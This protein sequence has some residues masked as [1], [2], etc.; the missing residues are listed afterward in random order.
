MPLPR[1]PLDQ[2]STDGAVNE[3][4]FRGQ[5]KSTDDM[6]KMNLVSRTA[7]MCCPVNLGLGLSPLYV[8][9]GGWVGLDLDTYNFLHLIRLTFFVSERQHIRVDTNLENQKQTVPY[10]T[11]HLLQQCFHYSFYPFRVR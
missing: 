4:P 10:A 9:A 5:L 11:L 7:K 1:P 2:G 3:P 8:S 6:L